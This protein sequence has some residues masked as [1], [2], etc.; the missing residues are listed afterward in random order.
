MYRTAVGEPRWW[1]PKVRK[2]Y[3]LVLPANVDRAVEAYLDQ[4]RGSCVDFTEGQQ[5][6]GVGLS[7]EAYKGPLNLK[8]EKATAAS[9]RL[10]GIGNKTMSKASRKLFHALEG[11][12]SSLNEDALE[13]GGIDLRKKYC[14]TEDDCLDGRIRP[15]TEIVIFPVVTVDKLLGP[16]KAAVFQHR[17]L[18]EPEIKRELDG[19]LQEQEDKDRAERNRKSWHTGREAPPKRPTCS[20]REQLDLNFEAL[21]ALL[22][23]T[24][25]HTNKL[26]QMASQLN[27]EEEEN[28]CLGSRVSSRA[29][30]PYQAESLP[31]ASKAKPGSKKAA[32]PAADSGYPADPKPAVDDPS[33][34]EDDNVIFQPTIE[35]RSQRT[36]TTE[37]ATTAV[38]YEEVSGKA[39]SEVKKKRP[40]SASGGESSSLGGF[41]NAKSGTSE[42]KPYES[43]A[44]RKKKLAIKLRTAVTKALRNRDLLAELE[45]SKEQHLSGSATMP[46]QQLNRGRHNQSP[47]LEDKQFVE[48]RIYDE[49]ASSHQTSRAS[50][51]KWNEVRRVARNLLFSEEVLQQ[52]LEDHHGRVD[53]DFWGSQF[54]HD[55]QEDDYDSEEDEPFV[56]FPP[57]LVDP[58]RTEKSLRW[59]PPS[60]HPAQLS[61]VAE[62]LLQKR[63]QVV[64]EHEIASGGNRVKLRFNFTG[65]AD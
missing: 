47:I 24:Y 53:D 21:K 50:M 57:D 19:K 44:S 62:R 27:Q 35:R 45:E 41:A 63:D 36:L 46:V 34:D 3:F 13:E 43:L 4:H 8:R 40:L 1:G 10:K 6:P 14:I 39:E 33:V 49:D 11:T 9:S 18:F 22:E 32:A 59:R 58:I 52:V 2:I 54:L 61:E 25:T 20:S 48:D 15:R 23:H 65:F 30:S 29:P 64:Q 60:P 42:E 31:K 5:L 7:N 56:R 12:K 37:E 28:S 16:L 55:I 51:K 26:V 38:R 17:R